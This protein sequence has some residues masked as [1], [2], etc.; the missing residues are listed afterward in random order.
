MP[1]TVTLRIEEE[2]YKSFLRHAK[3]ENRTISDFIEVAVK[4]HIRECDFADDFEMAEIRE[5]E[6]LVHRLKK[7]SSDAKKKRGKMIG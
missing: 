4:E 6:S 5:N 7:G 3:A 1:K 2:L